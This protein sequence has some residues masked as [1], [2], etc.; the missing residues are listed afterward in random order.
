MKEDL[1]RELKNQG[2]KTSFIKADKRNAVTPARRI[3]KYHMA[4]LSPEDCINIALA[5]ASKDGFKSVYMSLSLI[6]SNIRGGRNLRFLLAG[7]L[8]RYRTLFFMIP[9]S[10]EMHFN[11]SSQ[12]VSMAEAFALLGVSKVLTYPY[13]K[14]K[15]F[16]PWS[17]DAEIEF[18]HIFNLTPLLS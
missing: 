4:L 11:E 6:N 14:M 9:D 16:Q 12:V 5:E 8:A 18:E 10:K 17:P 7:R 2:I 3:S 1:I 13:F 15:K